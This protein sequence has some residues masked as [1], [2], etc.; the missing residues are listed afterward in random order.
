MVK[1]PQLL[2]ELLLLAGGRVPPAAAGAAAPYQVWGRGL[3]L[4]LG[5]LDCCRPLV[6]QSYAPHQTALECESLHILVSGVSPVAI[7]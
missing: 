2:L 6:E 5:G 4:P 1:F 7:G 3:P